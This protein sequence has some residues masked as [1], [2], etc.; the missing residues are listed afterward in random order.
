MARPPVLIGSPNAHVG[1]AAGIEILAAGGRALDAAI[2][3][4]TKREAGAVGALR[5]YRAA[6][7]AEG[8]IASGVSTEP[9][10]TYVYWVSG[11][12]TFAEAPRILVGP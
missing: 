10:R 9:D 1:M 3:D 2:M 6:I 8:N 7:D 5:N 4:G 12:A 11:M